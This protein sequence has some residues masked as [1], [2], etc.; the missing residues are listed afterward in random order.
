MTLVSRST[1]P[2]VSATSSSRL[3]SH[4]DQAGG[5]H[6]AASNSPFGIRDAGSMRPPTDSDDESSSDYTDSDFFRR[7]SKTGANEPVDIPS[8]S[9][10]ETSDNE[11]L[12]VSPQQSL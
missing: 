12:P 4:T 6:K 10:D 9:D 11:R 3:S 1:S 7:M 2:A 8:G 5:C